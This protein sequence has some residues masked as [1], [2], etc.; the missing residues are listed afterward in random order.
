MTV[1]K[2]QKNISDTTCFDALYTA[3][4]NWYLKGIV[5]I[6]MNIALAYLDGVT[7]FTTFDEVTFNNVVVIFS[8]TAGFAFT[9]NFL[10]LVLGRLYQCWRYGIRNIRAW[11]LVVGLLIWLILFGLTFGLRWATRG[12]ET[13]GM[14]NLMVTAN[15]LGTALSSADPNSPESI[16]STLLCGF[17]PLVTSLINLYLGVLTDDPILRTIRKLTVGREKIRIG[18]SILFAAKTELNLAW[19]EILRAYDDNNFSAEL[20]AIDAF[21]EKLIKLSQLMLAQKLK[22]PESISFCTEQTI[23]NTKEAHL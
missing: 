13:S 10:P 14:E 3:D 1:K 7:L 12:G 22:D 11:M 5:I 15:G 6:F 9:L 21:T 23:S 4:Q 19:E 2:M 8:L 20:A 16:A 18:I 17:N